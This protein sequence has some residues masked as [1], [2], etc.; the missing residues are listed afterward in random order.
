MMKK[1]RKKMMMKKKKK[2]KKISV[3]PVDHPFAELQLLNE[4]VN[5]NL[6]SFAGPV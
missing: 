6:S 1:K 5:D 4:E 3:V 2:K